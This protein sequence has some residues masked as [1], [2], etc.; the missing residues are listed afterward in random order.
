MASNNNT[1]SNNIIKNI[2]SNGIEVSDKSDYNRISENLANLNGKR[3]IFLNT[4][5]YYNNISKNNA[6]ANGEQGILIQG[7][8]NNLILENNVSDNGIFGIGLMKWHIRLI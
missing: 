1:I 8:D 5:C 7:S 3:G 4:E 2:S 6:N